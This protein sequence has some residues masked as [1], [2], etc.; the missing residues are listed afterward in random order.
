VRRQPSQCASSWSNYY[1][2]FHTCYIW[3][4]HVWKYQNDLAY[5]SLVCVTSSNRKH[6]VSQSFSTTS[7]VVHSSTSVSG[8]NQTGAGWSKSFCCPQLELQSLVSRMR[9]FWPNYVLCTRS[10]VSNISY[11]NTRNS[12]VWMPSNVIGNK[13]G[14]Q[15]Y[16]KFRNHRNLKSSNLTL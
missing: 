8:C 9:L 6:T 11:T 7:L 10:K 14:V 5:E 3:C 16:H 4:S 13:N 15:W 1:Y 12:P 2:L